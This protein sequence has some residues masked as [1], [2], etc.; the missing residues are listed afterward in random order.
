MANDP[1]AGL[2]DDAAG[3]LRFWFGELRPEQYWTQDDHVDSAIEARFS[4]L[5]DQLA[6]DVPADWLETARGRLAAVIVLDQFPRNMFR[7]SAK[8]FDTD[9]RALALAKE[10]VDTGLDRTLTIDE[11][12]FLHVPFQHSE[13]P[14][15]QVL[16]VALNAKLGAPVAL[17]FAEKHKLVI[18]RFGRFPHRNDVLGRETTDE[19]R[20]FLENESWFW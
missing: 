11:R 5:Y 9:A 15:D 2:P 1:L 10:T 18:D 20:D 17:D 14:D 3:V 6:A 4:T 7:G 16:S 12:K 13:I 8:A 19:E